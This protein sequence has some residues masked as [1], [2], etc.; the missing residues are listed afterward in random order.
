[1]MLIHHKLYDSYKLYY[2]RKVF[3]Y[4]SVFMMQIEDNDE[5]GDGDGHL[6]GGRDCC[7]GEGAGD[8]AGVVVV[9][10]WIRFSDVVVVVY[11]VVVVVENTVEEEEEE[12]EGAG[13][14]GLGSLLSKPHFSD[15]SNP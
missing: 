1:M 6:V 9:V 7:D 15:H 12:K 8:D 11:V 2:C 10:V 14:F 4:A 3:L 5:S 13:Q